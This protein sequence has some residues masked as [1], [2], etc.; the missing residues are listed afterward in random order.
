MNAGTQINVFGTV[1]QNT[2]VG[3]AT[4]VQYLLDNLPLQVHTLPAIPQNSYHFL[5]FSSPQLA[6]QQHTLVAAV[7]SLGPTYYLDYLT[8]DSSVN[9]SAPPVPSLPLCTAVQPPPMTSPCS[10]SGTRITTL[11]AIIVPSICAVLLAAIVVLGCGM[12]RR[13]LQPKVAPSRTI[14]SLTPTPTDSNMPTEAIS[15]RNIRYADER[16][17]EYLPSGISFERT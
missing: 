17:S 8:Y 13:R 3:N 2:G 10:A 4:T 7:T 9:T 14:I 15:G 11:A 16:A 5:F 12:H 6:H 1:P